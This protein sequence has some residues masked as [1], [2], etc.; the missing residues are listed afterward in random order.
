LLD[1]VEFEKTDI[2]LAPGDRLLLYSDGLTEC[3][4]PNGNLLDDDGLSELLI[5][6]ADKNGLDLVS[7]VAEALV[8]FHGGSD[9]PDDL[10]AALIQRI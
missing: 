4:D 8:D 7:S 3:P 1:D 6:C 5:K 2:Q 10:S 9:F